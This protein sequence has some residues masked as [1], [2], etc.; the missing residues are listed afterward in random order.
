MRG[1]HAQRLN[2][3][4]EFLRVYQAQ[5]A[6]LEREASAMRD[7]INLDAERELAD[8]RRREGSPEERTNILARRDA[9]LRALEAQTGAR[10]RALG[11]GYDVG[12]QGIQ[13]RTY[14]PLPRTTNP[15]AEEE[16]GM[17]VGEE[18][19]RRIRAERAGVDNARAQAMRELAGLTAAQRA[20][21]EL[22]AIEAE[23][24]LKI[25]LARGEVAKEALA[26]EDVMRTLRG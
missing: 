3:Q 10:Y 21:T 8:L 12:T 4:Q 19:V 23:R 25:E 22:Q 7:L 5:A 1:A 24:L 16:E 14:S 20:Q 15:Y 26:N 6:A 9:R 13:E 2:D 11:E 18:E 17:R